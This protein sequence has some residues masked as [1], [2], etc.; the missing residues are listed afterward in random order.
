MIIRRIA[1]AVGLFTLAGISTVFAADPP[2]TNSEIPVPPVTQFESGSGD[3]KGIWAAIAYSEGDARHGFFWGADK[4]PEAEQTALEHCKKAGGASCTIV[5]VF[6]NHRHWNDDD[7]SGFP[8]NHCGALAV[9]KRQAG[10]AR[11]WGAKSASTQKEAEEL[12]LS[13]C[14]VGGRQCEIRE[15]VCT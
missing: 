5:A 1:T 9:S 12:S 15:R 13:A 4:R 14:E 11:A 2:V 7:G 3:Q 6:R 10:E 8:Y